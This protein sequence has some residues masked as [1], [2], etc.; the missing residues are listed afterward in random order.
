MK[1]I[2]VILARG[3]S[4]RLP[5]KNILPLNGKPLIQYSIE[6]AYTCDAISHVFVS[7]DDYKI[8]GIAAQN[9]AGVIKRDE[10]LSGDTS[11]SSDALKHAVE[12][13]E[14]LQIDFDAVVLLQPTSPFRPKD[15]LSQCLNVFEAS[16][17]DSLITVSP[18]KHKFGEI[19]GDH[20]K[21]LNYN[22][23]QRT[24]DMQHLYFENGLIYITA[25]EIVKQ[26]KI[27]TEDLYPY[28]VD[29]IHAE[30]DIDT[31]NDL[32]YAEFLIS[33]KKLNE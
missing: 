20:F 24:Q 2:A 25:K 31:Q 22:F 23:E 8:A 28:T 10:S 13:I 7:T 17:R 32:D 12:E 30:I 15:L 3:G 26:G 21:P 4:K 27:F 5:N 29:S 14:A 33:K 1:F 9:N 19:K 18:L 11:K 16:G 6:Y